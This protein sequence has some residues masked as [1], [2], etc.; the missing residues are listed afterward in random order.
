M[1][2]LKLGSSGVQA[3]RLQSGAVVA[4]DIAA[5]KLQAALGDDVQMRARFLWPSAG[6]IPTAKKWL[7]EFEPDVLYM[8]IPTFWFA[9]ESV[10][11]RLERRFGR[12]GKP[13][14][15]TGLRAAD[16][17]KLAHNAVFRAGRR[18]AH[19]LIG[20]D[21]HFTPGYVVGEIEKLLRTVLAENEG[22]LVVIHGPQG[23][24]AYH[25]SK[26]ANRRAE[27]R[28]LFVD[29]RLRQL[30]TELHIPY[31]G[32]ALPLNERGIRIETTGDG[33][34]AGEQSQ[35][36]LGDKDFRYLHEAISAHRASSKRPPQ[37]PS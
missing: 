14:A 28:R 26:R 6:M 37:T 2:V 35:E 17:P 24:N 32:T 13:L 34:H 18:L 7:A 27:A 3:E 16:N 25:S 19:T 21:S 22:L 1:K 8:T 11:Q 36:F 31:F 10:P 29:A 20:G 5:T 9:Y 33:L 23:W 30:S 12:L 4:H 15:S